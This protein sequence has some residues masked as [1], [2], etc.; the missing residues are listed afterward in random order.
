MHLKNIITA[1]QEPLCFSILPSGAPHSPSNFAGPTPTMMM[2]MGRAAACRERKRNYRQTV[3]GY[4]W[5][6]DSHD[7]ALSADKMALLKEELYCV[8]HSR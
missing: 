5:F 1:V 4:A 3:V 7:S 6:S 8:L 2:D